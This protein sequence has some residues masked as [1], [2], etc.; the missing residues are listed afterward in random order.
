MRRLTLA[1]RCLM[2]IDQLFRAVLPPAHRISTQ[3][4]PGTPYPETNLSAEQRRH[5]AGLMR[6]NHAGEVCAQAL[7]RGQALTADLESVKSSMTQA[8]TEELNHLAWC[9]E[10]LHEL[11]AQPTVFNLFWYSGSWLLGVIA[12]SMGDEWSLGFV[13]ETERQVSNHLSKHLHNLPI[14]DLKTK[15]IL[16]QMQQD[17]A[18]HAQSARDAGAADLPFVI[19]QTMSWASKLLTKSSYYI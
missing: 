13:F 10:R 17:E 19:K 7:Y 12:G 16:T 2:E 15:A 1:D 3:A 18:H 14:N 11:G 6:V 5:V 8:A 4:N 9:E